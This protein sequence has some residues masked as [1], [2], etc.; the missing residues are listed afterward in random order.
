V[1]LGTAC[2][3]LAEAPTPENFNNAKQYAAFFG[4]TP[5]HFESGSSVK[6]GSHLSKIGSRHARKTLFMASVSVKNHNEDF[7]TFRATP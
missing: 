2:C 3:I 6:K 4:V 7:Q 5:R 1:G